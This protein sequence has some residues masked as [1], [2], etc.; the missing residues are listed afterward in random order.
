MFISQ[1]LSVLP[2]GLTLLILVYWIVVVIAIIAEDREPTTTLA[3]I[4]VLVLFPGIGLILY[5]FAGRDWRHR[6]P[7]RQETIAANKVMQRSMDEHVKPYQEL[8]DRFLAERADSVADKISRSITKSNFSRPMPVRSVEVFPTGKGFFDSL[9]K[10]LADAQRFIH[11]QY[12][13]W[14]YD[15]LTADLTKI[16]LDRAKAGVEI[17]IMYDWLG[18]IPFKKDEVKALVAA[19]ADMIPDTTEWGSAN[20]RNH[21]KI[22]VIDGDIGYTGGHN[23]GQEYIDGGKAYPSWRD[24]S[25]RITGPAVAQ[26]EAWI[27]YRWMTGG[28]KHKGDTSLFDAKYM[29]TPD[30]E[31]VSANPIMV[32]TVAQG[33]DDPWMS[34][35]RAHTVAMSGAKK[36]LHICS[37]YFVP[38]KGLYEAM[39]NAALAGLDVKFIMTGW[40]DHK[41]A[42]W[43]AQSYWRPIVEAGGHVYTYEAGFFHAKTMVVDSKLYAVGTMN[44]DLRSLVLQREIVLWV[45][46][47]QVAQEQE[48]VF[49]EDLTKSKEITLADL[50][51]MSA[52]VRFRNSAAR[53]TSN[54]L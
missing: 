51:A 52:G 46:D 8:A 44:L 50:D 12:F 14:E 21:R 2:T 47:E 30:P 23:I 17:R 39:I 3:W 54:L 27:A 32:Q 29:P 24:T 31:I 22:T 4:L 43:A 49:E 15:E 40:P 35:T 53:I 19:G 36:S 33:V 18:S 34:G 42:F 9:K 37:P 5:Y 6:V 26:L 38:D 45:Y 41:S 10:D 48:K 1:N 20:Y 11:M 16:L 28:H 13:I 25:C 7:K